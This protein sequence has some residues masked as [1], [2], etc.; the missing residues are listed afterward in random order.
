M[1]SNLT[2]YNNKEALHL[3]CLGQ[4][5]WSHVALNFQNMVKALINCNLSSYV[6]LVASILVNMVLISSLI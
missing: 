2:F 3:P 4:Q 6:G 5:Y 1:L